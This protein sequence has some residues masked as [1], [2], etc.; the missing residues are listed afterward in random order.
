ML[1]FTFRRLFQIALVLLAISAITFTLFYAGPQDPARLICGIKCSPAAVTAMRSNMGLDQPIATQYWHYL[2]GLLVGRTVHDIDGGPVACSA[3]CLGYSYFLKRPVLTAI[4]QSLPTTLSIAAGGVLML[5]LL[6]G[7]IGFVC[8]L[9]Q[10]TWIDRCL[11]VF[12]LVGSSLQLIFVGVIAQYYLV[13]DF[14]LLPQP[15]YVSPLTDFGQWCAGM[16]L[17]WMA[18]G[19]VGAAVY[20]RLAR[21]QMLDTMGEE[22]IKTARSKGM[23][24]LRIHV[25]YTTRG[26]LAP[27]VQLMGLEIGWL[28]GGSVIAEVVFGLNGLGKL[29]LN[30]ITQNDLPTIEGTVLVAGF[31]VVLF[32]ALADL[33]VALLDPRVRLA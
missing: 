11:S 8:A 6:G 31:S 26:G 20:A 15:Q 33:A 10:R 23:G 12:T 28:L 13:E 16:L 30:A 27:L 25:K 7:G 19:Y 4:G 21:T 1:A 14:H 9:R 3:P 5:A 32:V 22:Y 17:P 24:W 2:T 18:L 29:A